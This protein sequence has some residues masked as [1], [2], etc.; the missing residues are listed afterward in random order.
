MARCYICDTYIE[1]PVI[2][3]KTGKIAHCSAC[4]DEIEETLSDFHDDE[5]TV[6]DMQE[7]DYEGPFEDEL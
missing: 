3:P 7:V 1:K 2:D 4:Q 6:M 5:Y